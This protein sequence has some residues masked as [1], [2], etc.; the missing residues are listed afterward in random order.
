M[1]SDPLIIIQARSSSNRCPGKILREIKGKPLIVY[2]IERMQ[3]VSS[4]HVLIVATSNEKSDDPVEILCEEIGVICVRGPLNDVAGRFLKVLD[5]FSSDYFVRLSG[6]SP[7]LDHNIVEK[8]LTMMLDSPCD[9]VSNVV[10]RTFPKGQSVEILGSNFFKTAY[11]E[12]KTHS[13]KEHVTQF[14]YQ[15]LKSLNFQS[16]KTEID[17]SMIQLSVD[18][19]RDFE[20]A[21]K[22][23]GAMTRPHWN[24]KWNEIMRLKEKVEYC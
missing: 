24:Y 8:M 1:S 14:F 6:D 9:L 15:N 7:F 10:H 13:H 20:I 2:L 4:S 23:I 18:T 11:T 22:M 16:L 21:S 3:K 5:Q 17:H 19:E 12:F